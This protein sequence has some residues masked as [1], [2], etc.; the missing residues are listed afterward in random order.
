MR[1]TRG[2]SRAALAAALALTLL[3]GCVRVTMREP[4]GTFQ[5]GVAKASTSLGGYYTELNRFERDL[6][7]D[8]R[9]YDPTQDV[10]ATDA[11]KQ[12]T[13]LLGKVFNPE[14]IRAR[15]DAIALLGAYAERLT[16]L[17][18]N[19]SPGQFSAG[20]KV[21]G[22]S[23]GTLVQRVSTLANQGDSTAAKYVG[24]VTTLVGVLGDMYLES[25]R[26]KALEVA[27]EK[28]SPQVRAIIDLLEADLVDVIKPQRLTGLKQGLA[29]RLAYYND[30]REKLTLAERREVLEDLK[31]SVD[32]YEALVV[33]NPTELTGALRD[34]HEGLVVFAKS[35]RKPKNFDEFIGVMKG[36]QGRIDTASEAVKRTQNPNPQG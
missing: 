13:P 26:E 22:E 19:E 6:Y 10:L 21:G 5:A 20:A 31:K 28:G 4:I 23:L 35:E 27:V 15:Q 32:Q 34:A 30:A 24:P 33:F 36:F 2:R 11:R 12:P 17:A 3:Q 1:L 29:M 16:A 7:L 14:S 25:R 9:L 8:E 18:G